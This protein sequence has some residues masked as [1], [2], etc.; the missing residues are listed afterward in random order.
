MTLIQRE[1]NIFN[2]R[3]F[4]ILCEK[5]TV[6]PF[7]RVGYEVFI[8]PMAFPGDADQPVKLIGGM[9]LL[10]CP[11]PLIGKGDI[12]REMRAPLERLKVDDILSALIESQLYH[13]RDMYE[14]ARVKAG[15]L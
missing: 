10:F 11:H 12:V 15:L 13:L 8:G 5:T 1:I 4:N 9:V 7:P 6:H 14:E 3:V 2:D